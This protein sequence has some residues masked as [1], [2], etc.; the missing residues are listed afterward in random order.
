MYLHKKLGDSIKKWE[1]I[2]TLYANDET[3]LKAGIERL[4]ERSPFTI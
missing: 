1:I 3:S 4:N 2:A